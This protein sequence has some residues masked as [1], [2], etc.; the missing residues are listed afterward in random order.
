MISSQ[1]K[2]EPESLGGGALLGAASVKGD[3]H[4][5]PASGRHPGAGLGPQ[6]LDRGSN[7]GPS[8][9]RGDALPTAPSRQSGTESCRL[10]DLPGL[11]P[12][13]PCLQ[14]RCATSCAIGP[15]GI[16]RRQGMLATRAGVEPALS[17]S[18]A[19]RVASYTSGY[20]APVGCR[21][22]DDGS[23]TRVLLHGKQT[24]CL[25]ASSA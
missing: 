9:Y 8:P 14:G 22:A 5:I 18:R 1:G 7:P 20:R 16:P 15:E 17:R 2:S 25:W 3:P 19:E 13:T 10:V 21:R 12:G 4:A 23:R 6:S 24:P 11:E